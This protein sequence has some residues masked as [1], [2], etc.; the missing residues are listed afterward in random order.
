MDLPFAAA[1]LSAIWLTFK[2][3]A[4]DGQ[5]LLSCI[6]CRSRDQLNFV[7]GMKVFAQVKSVVLIA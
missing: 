2:L 4:S 1:D 7:I 6:T 5:I 3:V